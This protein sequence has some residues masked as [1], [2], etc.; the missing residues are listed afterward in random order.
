MKKAENALSMKWL[1]GMLTKYV[2][3][4]KLIKP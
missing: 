1:T 4:V 2:P 3:H